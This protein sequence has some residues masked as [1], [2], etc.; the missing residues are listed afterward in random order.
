MIIAVTIIR[1]SEW[2]LGKSVGEVFKNYGSRT[3]DNQF[4]DS[5]RMHYVKLIERFYPQS[6][7]AK[8]F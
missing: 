2:W 4:G 7:V 5:S 6:F 1:T 3:T 8:F